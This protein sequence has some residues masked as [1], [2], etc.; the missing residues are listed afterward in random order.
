MYFYFIYTY[1]KQ[2]KVICFFN[3]LL[4]L[5]KKYDYGKDYFY[6]H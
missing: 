1:I 3:T 6:Y 4:L 5:Q 2:Y